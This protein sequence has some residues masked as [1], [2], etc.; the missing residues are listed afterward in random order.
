MPYGNE[1]RMAQK[2]RSLVFG[3]LAILVLDQGLKYWLTREDA[4]SINS[5]LAFNLAHER[6]LVL[7]FFLLSLLIWRKE[8]YRIALM[9][10]FCAALTNLLDRWRTGGVVDYLS[11]GNLYFNLADCLIVALTVGLAIT[12]I[13]KKEA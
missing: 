4:A 7:G 9:L 10:I 8:R 6:W 12:E 3:V 2:P 1:L 11:L 13:T 5:R